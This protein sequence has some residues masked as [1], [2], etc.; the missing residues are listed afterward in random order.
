MAYDAENLKVGI[1]ESKTHLAKVDIVL[2][3]LFSFMLVAGLICFFSM[4]E[5]KIQSAKK[6]V[7][8]GG[9]EKTSIQ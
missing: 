7:K 2:I 8:F 4:R 1:M 3:G 6:A 5:K 9:E